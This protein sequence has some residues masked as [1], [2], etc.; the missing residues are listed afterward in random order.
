MTVNDSP[1]RS[2]LLDRPYAGGD[3]RP[4]ILAAIYVIF[5]GN[6]LH[7][8]LTYLL[9]GPDTVTANYYDAIEIYFSSIVY[10]KPNLKASAI[11][12]LH[13]VICLSESCHFLLIPVPI[14]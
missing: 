8:V 10:L 4:A 9:Q 11:I 6:D 3:C 1:E 5:I 7:P 2:H 14:S 12:R 13:C